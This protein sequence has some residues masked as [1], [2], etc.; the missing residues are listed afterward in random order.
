MKMKTQNIRNHSTAI[1]NNLSIVNLFYKILFSKNILWNTLTS[2]NVVKWEF[3]YPLCDIKP[4]S[5]SNQIHKN[6]WPTISLKDKNGLLSKNKIFFLY[7]FKYR[8]H[9]SLYSETFS[10]ACWIMFCAV[11]RSVNLS[12]VTCFQSTLAGKGLKRVW[13]Q[14]LFEDEKLWSPS[15]VSL[16][17]IM[18]KSKHG[19]RSEN[20]TIIFL[21]LKML[22]ILGISKCQGTVIHVPLTNGIDIYVIKE[23]SVTKILW[24]NTIRFYRLFSRSVNSHFPKVQ[25]HR[26]WLNTHWD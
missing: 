5:N 11:Y 1:Y 7:S 24:A 12:R 9:H 10:F 21:C 25:Y 19:V 26:I 2:Y 15:D 3:Q 20:F 8:E 22:Y 16:I 4:V 17:L 13:E 6:L 18:V 23:S 14:A